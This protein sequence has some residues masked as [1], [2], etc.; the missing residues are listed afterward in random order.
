MSIG[1]WP[2]VE[3]PSLAS[4][5]SESSIKAIPIGFKVKSSKYVEIGAA[6]FSSAHIHARSVALNFVLVITSNRPHFYLISQMSTS[7]A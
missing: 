7:H 4:T 3:V 1:V 5:C 6:E 2:K